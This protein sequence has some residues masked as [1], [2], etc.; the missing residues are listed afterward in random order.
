VEFWQ[1]PREKELARLFHEA[2]FTVFCSLH[3][4]FGLPVVESI[5]FGKPCLTSCVGSMAEIAQGGGCLTVDP[6]R[7]ETIAAGMERL[8]DDEDLYARL[9]DE[10]R[11]R[12]PRLWSDYAREIFAFFTATSDAQDNG[13]VTERT[14][15]M[16]SKRAPTGYD[17][18]TARAEDAR[19]EGMSRP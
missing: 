16:D 14:V 18:G 2:R 8:L 3:E 1:S 6:T 15:P 4:G 9:L 11:R 10:I 19:R 12:P 17:Q 7:P 13:A 5:A